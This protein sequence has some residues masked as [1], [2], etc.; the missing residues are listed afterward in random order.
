MVIE[1]ICE[2][3]EGK[4]RTGVNMTR[5]LNCGNFEDTCVRTNRE[6]SRVSRQVETHTEWESK[7]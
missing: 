1:P 2:I 3:I 6:I 5:C 4:F 7:D